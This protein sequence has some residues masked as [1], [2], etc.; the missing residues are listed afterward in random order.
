MNNINIEEV[1]R[2]FADGCHADQRYGDQPYMTHIDDVVF[3]LKKWGEKTSFPGFAVNQCII[4]GYLHD[5]IE[6]TTATPDMI[7]ALFDNEVAGIVMRVTDA[8]GSNR[9]ERKLRSYPKMAEDVRAVAVK[10]ADRLANVRACKETDKKAMLKL[11][12]SE[13]KEFMQQLIID[14]GFREILEPMITELEKEIE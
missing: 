3:I 12:Q 10:V 1:A 5:T 14:T 9:K 11:Y 7:A 8:E 2:R 6:D 13:H 4:A